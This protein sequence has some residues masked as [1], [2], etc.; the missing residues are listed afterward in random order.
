MMAFYYLQYLVQSKVKKS[1]IIECNSQQRDY[2]HC[3]NNQ[4][5]LPAVAVI[6]VLRVATMQHKSCH[7]HELE[8]PKN[9]LN[10]QCEKKK[11]VEENIIAPKRCTHTFRVRLL[12]CTTA[13][14][15]TLALICMQALLS[16][17]KI[18]KYT[19]V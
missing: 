5:C 19:S 8:N 17:H 3:Y 11:E 4:E 6:S 16:S 2:L 18:L 9:V 7:A 1:M 10:C 15:D 14:D 13:L 12:M